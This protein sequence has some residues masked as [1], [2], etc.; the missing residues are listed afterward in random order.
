MSEI[1]PSLFKALSQL[2]GWTREV[3]QM[4]ISWYLQIRNHL[5]ILVI[6]GLSPFHLKWAHKHLV[7]LNIWQHCVC[8]N[9]SAHTALTGIH[10]AND[11]IFALVLFLQISW[12]SQAHE[13]NNPKIKDSSSFHHTTCYQAKLLEISTEQQKYLAYKYLCIIQYDMSDSWVSL[14]G[15]CRII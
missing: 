14:E 9:H 6:G 12:I 4:K 1:H 2:I 13:N 11:R 15:A 8:I 10:T 5:R 7:V 3:E